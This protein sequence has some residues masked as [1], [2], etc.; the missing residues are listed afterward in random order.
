M[1][2][3]LWS[4]SVL[5]KAPV[6][7]QNSGQ[8]RS[9]NTHQIST[10]KFFFIAQILLAILVIWVAQ[11]SIAHAQNNAR[12]LPTA[13]Q[14]V[15]GTAVITQSGLQTQVNQAS[16]RAVVNWESFNVGK[17]ATVTFNQPNSSAVTLNRVTGSS[18]SVIDG[19]IKANGQ[20]VLVNPNGVTFGKG[21]QVDAAGVVATTMNI[22]NKD[23]MDG[24][25]TYKGDGTGK[26]INEGTI[27]ANAKDGYIALLAPEVRN[28]GYLIAK[29]GSG[30]V[31]LAAGKQ[32]TLD[33]RGDSLISVKVDESAINALIE[34]KRLVK[35]DGGLV[36]IA[37]GAANSLMSSVIRNTGRISASSM[38]NNGGIIELVASTI[39]QNGTISANG[40]GAN[41]NGGKITLQGDDITL[42]A[43]STINAKG[44]VNGG[45]VNVGT[46]NVQY[47]QNADG[48]RTNVQA[49]NLAKTVVLEAGATIDASSTQKGDGG[50]INLWSS[51]KTTVAGTLK[52]LGG[53]LGGNGGYIETS[54]AGT[55][56]IATTAV[57]DVS[58]PK[59][60]S[61][62]WLLD[63][64]DLVVDS[65]T[66]AAIST[67][68]STSNVTVDVAGNLTVAAGATISGAGNLTLN[69][70]GTI[71]NNGAITTGSTSNLVMNSAA[72]SLSSGSTTSANQITATAQAVTVNGAL[73]S[74]GGSTG[75]INVTGG[76]IVLSGSVSSNGSSSGSGS[77][78]SSSSSTTVVRT[79]EEE[80]AAQAP[81]APSANAITA[82]AQ[83]TAKATAAAAS[84]A[85][86]ATVASNNVA[87]NAVKVSALATPI[88]PLMNVV[89]LVAPN[90]AVLNINIA[91]A[92][93]AAQSGTTT[94][95]NVASAASTGVPSAP[96]ASLTFTA[97][98][99]AQVAA[100]ATV[101]TATPNNSGGTI[102]LV[103]SSSVTVSPT[104]TITANA[105]VAPNSTDNAQIS[106]VGGTIS[107]AA[108]QVTTQ[109]GS[110]MQANGNNGP[111]GNFNL[112]A[113]QLSIAGQVQA[114]GN[115]GGTVL[116]VA[117][118]SSIQAGSLIQANGNNGPGG[119][120]TLQTVNNQVINNAQIQANGSG[121]GGNIQITTTS[122]DINLQSALIQTNGANG[123]GG[124]VG[125]AATNYTSLESST[126]E[127]TGFTQGGTIKVGN[128]APTT[129]NAGGTLPFSIFT[130]LD[131]NSILNAA[132]T[133]PANTTNGGYIETSG[134]IVNLLS[135]IN[136]GRGGMWLLDPN[137]LSISNSASG[138]AF[139]CGSS[140]CSYTAGTNSVI[141]N[142][143]VINAL[144][145]GYNV[146][147][148][149]SGNISVDQGIQV[150]GSNTETLTLAAGSNITLNARILNN[151]SE[152]SQTSYYGT[153]NLTLNATGNI[154]GSIYA[155]LN[156]SGVSTFNVGLGSG[157]IQG[158]I[159]GRSI[160]KTGSG[161]LILGHYSNTYTGGTEITGGTIR[162][163][164]TGT[165]AL[166]SGNV[167]IRSAGTLDLNSYSSSNSIQLYGGTITNS[168]SSAIS[169][170][171]GSITLLATTS[172]LNAASGASLNMNSVLSDSGAGYGLNY[173]SSGN[174]GTVILSK[175][176]T[177][178]GGTT[179][180]GGT[181]QLGASNAIGSNSPVIMADNTVLD[182]HGFNDSIY[183][184]ATSGTGGGVYIQNSG[185]STNTLTIA[186]SSAFTKSFS[187]VIRDN[188]GGTGV[189]ALTL[190]SSGSV[191]AL[192][193]TNTY[194]G[195]T[196]ISA[197]TLKV[198]NATALGSNSGAVSVASG[199][200]LDLN[201]ITMTATNA[202]TLNGTGISSGGALL[203]SNSTAATYA[204]LITL[205]SASS[206]IGGTGLITLSN[207]GTITGSGF[208]LTL[209]GAQGGAVNSVIGT[210]AGTLTKQD[211]GTW[212][213]TNTNTYSGTTTIS[214]G[215]LKLANVSGTTIPTTAAISMS[216]GTLDLDG[217]SQIIAALNSTGGTP[218]VTNSGLSDV[219]LTFGG[220]SPGSFSGVIQDGT[221]KIAL[222]L[223]SSSSGTLT[224]SGTN[225]Y[226]GGTTISA[227]TLKVGNATAL[228]SNSGA[229]SVASGAALD[230]NG[231]TMTATNALTLNGTGISSGGALLNSNST[232][233][234][235]AGLITLGSASSIIGGT[236]LITLSNSGTITGSG[237]GLTLGGA[238]GGAVNSVIGTNAG[239]LTKQDAGTWT[240]TNTNTYSGT[241]T[242]SAGTLQLGNGTSAGWISNSS[243]VTNNGTLIFNEPVGGGGDTYSGVI[244]GSGAVKQSGADNLIFGN[245][246]TANTYTG[247]T[248]ITSG[249]LTLGTSGAL[250]SDH[251]VII[252]AGT[253]DINGLT[254]NL[255]AGTIS[256]T[257]AGT[258]SD[259]I[260][261]GSITAASYSATN[262]SGIATISAVLGDYSPTPSAFTMN[263]SGGT[264]ML[265]AANTYTGATT[266][267]AGTLK[268]GNNGSVSGFGSLTVSLGGTLDVAGLS[269][270]IPI[271]LNGGTITSSTGSSGAITG[272]ITLGSSISYLSAAPT[273]TLTISTTAIT[274]GSGGYALTIGSSANTGNVVFSSANSYSGTTTVS[275]GK[276]ILDTNGNIGPDSSNLVITNSGT[277]D[278]SNH[279]LTVNN[280]T[281][282]ASGSLINSSNNSNLVVNGTGSIAGSISNGGNQTYNG[283]VLVG[284]ASGA[285]VTPQLTATGNV[286]FNS[287][288]DDAGVAGTNSLTV[289]SD[290]TGL[291]GSTN[292]YGTVG[293]I[294]AL[295]NLTT[296]GIANLR[297]D[298]Y[299]KGSQSYNYDV[300]LYANS[301]S[302]LTNNTVTINPN[303]G[304]VTFNGAVNAGWAMGAIVS[305]AVI[306]NSSSQLTTFKSVIG[307]VHS[308]LNLIIG[309]A[310][311]IS[312][313][314]T[315]TGAQTYTGAVTLGSDIVLTSSAAG[316]SGDITFSSTIDSSV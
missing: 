20:V 168:N 179:I 66:A 10:Q 127:A 125:I 36:I 33:F 200:A 120:I 249:T 56:V 193:G 69:A 226:S 162:L 157:E 108:P 182:L 42:A 174:A 207:S 212:T 122:G 214:A 220:A 91:Q 90:A 58:A 89:N 12:A 218:Y 51:I 219:T 268:L 92:A 244:T 146:T 123:R 195:G 227:G 204:G 139:S 67:A 266:V 158:T 296:I 50:Q 314:I 184:L 316:T 288:V 261:G 310:S 274:E 43:G 150:T 132:Q 61:G 52:A 71:T 302:Q 45:T 209:G 121:N 311:L 154:S 197:G 83:T 269:I 224:L 312:A 299:T 85:A 59:G 70:T 315:T 145:S 292:F 265:L 136:A 251:D 88:S 289:S 6:F 79:K 7:I 278:L 113:T 22:S 97:Q 166:G 54:S 283:A 165:N 273:A 287:T 164:N 305:L 78:S 260:G 47:T 169:A 105:T 11:I 229:V 74:S 246:F 81:A 155:P 211:A 253:L 2:H 221:K 234:T 55:L 98:T 135:S 5:K 101:A 126:V 13:G 130:N 306:P 160:L 16:Q 1:D 235:Y 167:V 177:Y 117:T 216:G 275:Y 239:T 297:S 176:N 63:P 118:S 194:S 231:I 262:T 188:N 37:A 172:N 64:T 187:G 156:V 153:L 285:G 180:S 140:P 115:T 60:K 8:I 137:D 264:L 128:D 243:S 178:T 62:M 141:T 40:K 175:A 18:P 170:I 100:Q 272:G 206:I 75:S 256:I 281:I 124:Q 39:S 308:P 277:L 232:A 76:A 30:T 129:N 203:N 222:T 250:P 148:S 3:N 104:A 223:N 286:I 14:V 149:A 147:L 282:A 31:A 276:L 86:A 143:S 46:T 245:S 159:D 80:L 257:G 271:N 27:S 96:I 181:L 109:T 17:D 25:S 183:S 298:V 217:Y 202:L 304:S 173:G 247:G 254:V 199:A 151:A 114:N 307:D 77:S 186:G 303:A 215:T 99:P 112:Q 301:L 21:S 210:N 294:R 213:L 19:A 102:T 291:W 116:A 32:I 236:G 131:I 68:L 35:V 192:S 34:N 280:L 73:S 65:S 44:T 198:G 9:Q 240:L 152:T 138:T 94:I 191:Q 49:Q 134:Q 263:G 313:A 208:G 196:T 107:I 300:Y 106:G 171:T 110:V 29:I 142:T 290:A 133:N 284:N 201:G 111:G 144:N 189:V 241:T 225:T 4:I 205:G 233:A 57:V 163:V 26:I 185:S 252:G 23:F 48:T 119:A 87:A 28:D 228:G 161:T 237:F 84:A 270:N 242:I 267:S 258:L 279:N 53:I 15:A 82:A 238:Q 95:I 230:L 293:G 93:S 255:G 41:A 190:N 24:K 309:G 72:L 259:S 103:A 295:N 38:V 248:I